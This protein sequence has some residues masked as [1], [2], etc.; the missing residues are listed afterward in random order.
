MDI[1]G[2]RPA[3]IVTPIEGTTRDVLE[4]SLNIGGYPLILADTAGLHHKTDDVIEKEGINRALDYCEKADLI[5]L[6]ADVTKYLKFKK[7][8]P[9]KSFTDYL[10]V[11]V[12]EL[13]L[14]DLKF[15]KNSIIIFNKIDLINECDME[16][17]CGLSCKDER[18]FSE[19]IHRITEQLIDL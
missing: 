17:N 12:D 18:G 11:Y 14:A 4:V 16:G 13:Q 6:V 9:Q 2:Q 1:A 8:N 19:L 5:L 7:I 15:A 10:K 3:A